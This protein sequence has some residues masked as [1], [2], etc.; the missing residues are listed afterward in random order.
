MSLLFLIFLLVFVSTAVAVYPV[1]LLAV[2]FTAKRT[3]LR[4]CLLALLSA[5]LL[6]LIVWLLSYLIGSWA[7]FLLLIA[8]GITIFIFM[9]LLGTSPANGIMI[10]G[11][12]LGVSAVFMFIMVWAF[13]LSARLS[14]PPVQAL[15]ARFTVLQQF[16]TASR[17]ICQCQTDMRCLTDKYLAFME[18]QQNNTVAFKPTEQARLA[19]FEQQALNCSTIVR[20]GEQGQSLAMQV[21]TPHHKA[22]ITEAFLNQLSQQARVNTNKSSA[23]AAEAIEKN[24][25]A[26]PSSDTEVATTEKPAIDLQ[27]AQQF[28]KKRIRITKLDGNVQEGYLIGVSSKELIIQQKITPSAFAYRVLL[29]DIF[30]LQEIN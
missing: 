26:E 11:G 4:W 23:L 22:T 15:V 13:G 5:W 1:H 17:A 12:G 2:R 7:Y 3:R 29:T 10:M 27:Q 21:E 24:K 8:L 14:P 19:Y 6:L 16:A 25:T 28:L 20:Q 30:E 18:L 9:R